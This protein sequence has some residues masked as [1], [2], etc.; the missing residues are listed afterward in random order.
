MVRKWA[1]FWLWTL[2]YAG[3]LHAVTPPIDAGSVL[4]Q[5]QQQQRAP[6]AAAPLVPPLPAASNALSAPAEGNA[7]NTA[8]IRIKVLG[9][10][11]E[12][13]VTAFAPD[14]L[15][16][17][18]STATGQEL[19]LAE[20]RAVADRITALYRD[21][22]YF[23]ARAVLPPQDVTSGTV[24]VL[25]LEGRLDSTDGVRL[26]P[27]N[28]SVPLKLDLALARRIVT[29]PLSPTGALRLADVERGILLLNDLPGVAA[30]GN[31]EPGSAPD[32]T[33]LVVDISSTPALNGAVTFD[34]HGS[35]YTSSNRWG[36]QLSANNILGLGDQASAQ[37]LLSPNG[38]YR[39]ARLGY[40]Q[41]ADARGLR[42]GGTV[43]SLQYRLGADL[44][45]LDAKGSA[46]V[47]G[48]TASYPLL[49]SRSR[50]LNL[51]L[52]ADNKRLRN[53]SLGVETSNKR[54]RVV[55]TTLSGDWQD[56]LGGSL[57]GG[58]TLADVSLGLGQLDLSANPANLQQDQAPQG[59]LTQ[60]SFQRLNFGMTRVQRITPRLNL[61]AQLQGQ[62]ARKNLD[63]SEK[64]LL[65][66]ANGVRAYPSGEAAGDSGVRASVD[67]RWLAWRHASVG[68]LNLQ[69]F[70]DW[71][72]VKQMQQPMVGV[73]T[74]PN[75]LTLA[76]S[77]VGASLSHA[78]GAELRLTW[79]FK[80]GSNPGRNP[81]TGA[82][83]D[84][85][86]SPHR[87]WLSLQARF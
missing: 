14:R 36:A 81:L 42:L 43:N 39:Y 32:T 7:Q 21:A 75:R 59:A 38:D 6:A 55:T 69:A 80:H 15:M 48:L 5:Q 44:A 71:G 37:L 52:L 12:G 63:S 66:G 27:A 85:R 61:T 1:G 64:F 70:A 33:R 45:P 72:R 78:S 84:G 77:G 46:N 49:R 20:L 62:W 4:Q 40:S 23:L 9:F 19:S 68:A 54:V 65:G 67:A 31:L 29:A 86:Q 25:V 10:K 13:T 22:G 16:A 83:A 3:S 11:L 53:S 87:V 24:T 41:L 56:S 60:G 34:N 28:P 50:N 17:L 57:N 79:A 8:Q 26:Q 73:Q 82:D 18:L 47:L 74:T 58:T 30:S 2:L 51:V 76:G 35:R